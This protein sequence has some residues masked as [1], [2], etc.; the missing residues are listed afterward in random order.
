MKK[1][2][3]ESFLSADQ[4]FKLI[5]QWLVLDIAANEPPKDAQDQPFLYAQQV[6]CKVGGQISLITKYS[7]A[8]LYFAVPPMITLDGVDFV[9]KRLVVGKNKKSSGCYAYVF[10]CTVEDEEELD[11]Q[12]FCSTIFLLNERESD[13]I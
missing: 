13:R 3:F 8:N 7:L 10:G 2:D 4:L 6:S 12:A 1:L 11:F 9:A 5:D